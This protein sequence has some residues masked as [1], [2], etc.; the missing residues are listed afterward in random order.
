MAGD[1]SIGIIEAHVIAFD[2]HWRSVEPPLFSNAVRMTVVEHSSPS[3]SPRGEIVPEKITRG[4]SDQLIWR[5]AKL[6]RHRRIYLR[7]ALVREHVVEDCFLI[8]GVGPLDR[9][10]EHHEKKSV[11]R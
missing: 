7:H 2:P 11:P 4:A 5:R 9:L 1:F 3:I 10:I 8:D 6:L